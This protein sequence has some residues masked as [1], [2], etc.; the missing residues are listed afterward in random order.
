MLAVTRFSVTAC[1]CTVL[2]NLPV[3]GISGF[4]L[5]RPPMSTV[6]F[7]I[8]APPPPPPRAPNALP[9]ANPIPGIFL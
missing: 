3:A 9:I 5:E 7:H 6:G 8:S 4:P 2:M 1:P